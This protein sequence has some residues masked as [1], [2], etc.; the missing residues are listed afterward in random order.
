MSEEIKSHSLRVDLCSD[1][2]SVHRQHSAACH[3]ESPE[4][5]QRHSNH[6]AANAH[7]NPHWTNHSAA[8]DARDTGHQHHRASN[9]HYDSRHQHHRASNAHYDSRHQYRRASNAHYDSRQQHHLSPD[10][11]HPAY[12]R[13]SCELQQSDGIQYSACC[14]KYYNCWT[15]EQLWFRTSSLLRQRQRCQGGRVEAI[16]HVP[17]RS[18]LIYDAPDSGRPVHV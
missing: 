8:N 12:C 18:Y 16:R 9:T 10:T 2:E 11:D 14:D 4:R 17:D 7:N 13:D 5:E 3:N 6:R 15:F 1:A